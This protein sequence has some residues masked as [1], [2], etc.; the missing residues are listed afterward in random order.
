MYFR[1]HQMKFERTLSEVRRVGDLWS[2]ACS[3][4]GR[5]GIKVVSYR[6]KWGYSIPMCD[7]CDEEDERRFPQ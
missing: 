6:R 1:M 4:C 3:D 2:V 5:K 7:D